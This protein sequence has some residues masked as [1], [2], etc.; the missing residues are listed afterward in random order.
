MDFEREE[1]LE[2][3]RDLRTNKYGNVT[4]NKNKDISGPKK[5]RAPRNE[6]E[7]EFYK[8]EQRD[9]DLVDKYMEDPFEALLNKGNK[10]SKPKKPIPYKPPNSPGKRQ[11][12]QKPVNGFDERMTRQIRENNAKLEKEDNYRAQYSKVNEQ[13][14]ESKL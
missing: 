2:E 7:L 1:K 6:I 11:P 13:Q 9:R 5:V 10:D 8:Q 3:K 14:L 12:N 4:D